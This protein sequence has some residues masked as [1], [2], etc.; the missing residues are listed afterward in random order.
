LWVRHTLQQLTYAERVQALALTS[1][2]H[3]S[4]AALRSMMDKQSQAAGILGLVER[5]VMP[6][7]PHYTRFGV[8]SVPALQVIH[9]F[10][11]I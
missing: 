8:A 1:E 5:L 2:L 11:T 10:S 4:G 7:S 9:S 3:S 6:D